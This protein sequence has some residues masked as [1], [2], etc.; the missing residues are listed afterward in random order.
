MKK[1]LLVSRHDII[2]MSLLNHLYEQGFDSIGALRDAEAV[3]FLRSF[4]PDLVILGGHFDED[5]KLDLTKQLIDCQ[6]TIKIISYAGGVKNLLA[7]VEK[8]LS[9]EH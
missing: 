9:N 5:E 1:V 4:K 8:A 6:S 3:A 7:T 2:L